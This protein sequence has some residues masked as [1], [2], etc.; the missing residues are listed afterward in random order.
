M[1]H[2]H[3]VLQAALVTNGWPCL[4]ERNRLR[5]GAEVG[6]S[7]LEESLIRGAEKMI[8]DDRTYMGPGKQRGKSC[9]GTEL[10]R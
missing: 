10:E 4:R 1:V 2:V 9:T 3:I 5:Q 7:R 8:V 6:I